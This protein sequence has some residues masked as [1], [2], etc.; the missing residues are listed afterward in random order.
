MGAEGIELS[1]LARGVQLLVDQSEAMMPFRR[2]QKWLVEQL[3]RIAGKHAFEFRNF[4][5]CPSRAMG[6]G[7]RVDW[8][9]YRNWASPRTGTTIV[10]VTDLGITSAPMRHPKARLEEWLDFAGLVRAQ[11]C[12]IV[13]LVPFKPDRV[14]APLH[15]VLTVIH[16]DR[17]TTASRVRSVVGKGL[18]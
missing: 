1:T 17:S 2:D 12:P 16:W 8:K 11:A 13:A 18:R 3:E 14:P 10:V 9:P 4:I 5:G 15:R 7:P 6:S